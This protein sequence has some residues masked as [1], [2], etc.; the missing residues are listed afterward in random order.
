M[1]GASGPRD[2]W[3]IFWQKLGWMDLVKVTRTARD[4][5]PWIAFTAD[6]LIG[7]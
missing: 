7:I 1:R 4:A 3:A 5:Y 2:E 6:T